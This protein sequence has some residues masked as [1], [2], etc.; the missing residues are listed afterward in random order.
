MDG[1]TALAALL[2]VAAGCSA[3]SSM[4][5]A[6]ADAPGGFSLCGVVGGL[7]VG[8]A[9]PYGLQMQGRGVSSVSYTALGLDGESL[10]IWGD[11][12]AWQDSTP[13]QVSGWL[14]APPT[15]WVA[16]GDWICGTAGTITH[17]DDDSIDARLGALSIIPRCEGGTSGSSFDADLFG[18]VIQLALSPGCWIGFN[19]N[20]TPMS[21]LTP[22]CPQTGVPLPLDGGR[23]VI[24][25]RPETTA[26]IGS[27]ATLTL[28][29]DTSANGG[30]HLVVDIPSMSVPQSCGAPTVPGDWLQMTVAPW[31]RG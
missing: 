13:R 31:P 15:G 1:V 17:Q 26:C 4:A 19:A 5:C 8:F 21:L 18:G 6:S 2:G 22:T 3:G 16:D 24:G 20:G 12:A 14:L 9:P 11:A 29:A 23:V 28:M 7:P 25:E 10:D 30:H 27:G